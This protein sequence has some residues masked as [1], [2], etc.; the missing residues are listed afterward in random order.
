M[1]RLR[2]EPAARWLEIGLPLSARN[3]SF[4]SSCVQNKPASRFWRE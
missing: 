1:V 4:A 3:P 2:R